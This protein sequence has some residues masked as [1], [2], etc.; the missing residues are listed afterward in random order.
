MNVM[1]SLYAILQWF[2]IQTVGFQEHVM[3]KLV[4]RKG[5]ALQ[6]MYVKQSKKMQIKKNVGQS[7]QW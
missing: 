3:G 2:Q 7:L 4:W 5:G 6:N 1:V